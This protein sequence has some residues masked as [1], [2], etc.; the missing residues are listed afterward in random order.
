MIPILPAVAGALGALAARSIT[1]NSAMPSWDRSSFKGSSVS[2]TGG[3]HAAAGAIASSAALGTAGIASAIAAGSG[4]V[5]GYVDDHLE[6]KFP[7]K[8]KGFKGHIGALKE[9]KVTSGL[10]KIVTVGAGAAVSAALVPSKRTS[11]PGK[12][13]EYSANTLLI[14]GTANLLNLLD[15]RPGRALKAATA[16]AAPLTLTP[17]KAAPIAAGVVGTSLASL[18]TDLAGET[19]LGDL[20]ANALGAQLGVALATCPSVVVKTV[21]L[22]GVL[23]LTAA[24]EKVSFSKVIESNPVLSAIDN[25]GR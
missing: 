11:I 14:A 23:G 3:L 10:V 24:S 16:I 5:A 15:L 2:L 13:V 9:G 7:A 20:G 25:L 12:V 4:A 1:E 8:G 17:T 22:A 18:P 21:A 19:M 6:D